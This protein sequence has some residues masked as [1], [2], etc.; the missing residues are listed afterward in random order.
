MDLSGL[1][2]FITMVLLKDKYASQLRDV[3][4]LD[5]KFNRGYAGIDVALVEACYL[6]PSREGNGIHY[7][8]VDTAGKNA[9]FYLSKEWFREK[10][11]G[12][13][14]YAICR[15]GGGSFEFTAY[16][17]KEDTV[18]FLE[19][20]RV[21]GGCKERK[22]KKLWEVISSDGAVGSVVRKKLIVKRD[23]LH[24]GFPS[25]LPPYPLLLTGPRGLNNMLAF[26]GK[27]LSA[28]YWELEREYDYVISQR[29]PFADDPQLLK[30]LFCVSLLFRAHY[31]TLE[32]D[33]AE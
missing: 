26:F 12:L 30:I 2:T 23:S 29:V 18:L 13:S 11:S 3:V 9:G 20:G 16:S 15:L 6:P 33:W 32:L 7:P 27:I 4:A 5:R 24:V 8:L 14:F 1:D 25:G 21:F 31:F 22:K 10:G 28:G 17:G 19:E